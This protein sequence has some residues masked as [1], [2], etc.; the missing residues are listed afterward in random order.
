MNNFS[1]SYIYVSITVTCLLLLIF[2][3]FNI[4]NNKEDNSRIN[5]NKLSQ[6]LVFTVGEKPTDFIQRMN[7]IGQPIG[8][9]RQPAGLNFYTIRSPQGTRKSAR[10]EHEL[11]SFD[12][13]PMMKYMG[14]EDADLP[15]L[16]IKSLDFT[17]VRKD[18][19]QKNTH[20]QA[21]EFFIG[22]IKMLADLGWQR[23][24]NTSEPRLSGLQSYQY[25][26][27]GNDYYVPDLNVEP[28][29]KTWKAMGNTHIWTLYADN[30]FM[31]IKY[32]RKQD[33]SD[34]HKSPDESAYYIFSL[35][36]TTRDEFAKSGMKFD[37]RD[38]WKQHWV[39][40][41]KRLKTLRYKKEA[42]L[43]EKGYVIDTDY[44]DPIIHPNDPVEPD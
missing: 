4:S 22:Y 2:F 21:R 20:E 19:G 32:R 17:F 34:Q 3:V 42:D 9:N 23:F 44:L 11:Y 16:G 27:E 6:P 41:M 26:L 15:E 29:L 43:N 31:D 28:S 38:T 1:L 8:V 10:I 35:E 40:I 36:I 33:P 14:T 18:D 24:I 25:I 7:N 5:G 13:P 12:I 30:L 39:P 37:Q